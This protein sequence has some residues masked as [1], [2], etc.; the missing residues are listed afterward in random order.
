[1]I[2]FL[3]VYGL[4]GLANV[5]FMICADP[6]AAACVGLI[7]WLLI[8]LLWPAQYAVIIFFL[9]RNGI[10]WLKRKIRRYP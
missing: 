2:T 6:N 10:A 8:F 4:I 9:C 1:M 3:T 7:E 5:I